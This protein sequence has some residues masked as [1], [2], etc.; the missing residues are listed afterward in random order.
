MEHF[1]GLLQH[2]FACLTHHHHFLR[3]SDKEDLAKVDIFMYFLIL[4]LFQ[5]ASMVGDE[6]R[7]RD[8]ALQ[9]RE[10]ERPKNER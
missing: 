9:D 8:L 3:G 10:A 7:A 5:L 4:S 1:N 6:L 2:F